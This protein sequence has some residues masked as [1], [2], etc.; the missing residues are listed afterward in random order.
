M[1]VS[2]SC[3]AQALKEGRQRFVLTGV[4]MLLRPS[5]GVFVTMN[6][7]YAGRTELPDNLKVMTGQLVHARGRALVAHGLKLLAACTLH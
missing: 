3:C 1:R 4:E 7:G 2:L 5:C 6:P